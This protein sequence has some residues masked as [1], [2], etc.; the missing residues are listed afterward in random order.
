MLLQGD[1]FEL[2]GVYSD[3]QSFGSS[4]LEGFTIDLDD[5]F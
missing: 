1:A 5:I 2:E 4:T 3:A